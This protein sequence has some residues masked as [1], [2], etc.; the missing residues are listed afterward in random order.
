MWIEV[1][2]KYI[3]FVWQLLDMFLWSTE[4]RVGAQNKDIMK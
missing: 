2:G 3:L 1:I 4:Y